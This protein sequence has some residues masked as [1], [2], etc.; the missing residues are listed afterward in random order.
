MVWSGG[1]LTLNYVNRSRF[2]TREDRS[3]LLFTV[4]LPGFVYVRG[5]DGESKNGNGGGSAPS[6][7]VSKSDLEK[8]INAA[9]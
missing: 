3:D 2:P 1:I 7:G 4:S 9:V 6:G 8:P 5:S